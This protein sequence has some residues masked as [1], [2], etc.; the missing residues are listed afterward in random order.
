MEDRRHAAE[1]LVGLAPEAAHAVAAL[2]RALADEDESTRTF[3]VRTLVAMGDAAAQA[4][5]AAIGSPVADIRAAALSALHA[6]GPRAAPYTD[7]MIEAMASASDDATTFRVSEVLASIG[8]AA[9]QRLVAEMERR[10]PRTS[11]GAARA[12]AKMNPAPLAC[13]DVMKRWLREPDDGLRQAATTVVA[14]WT[15]NT[16]VIEWADAVVPLAEAI[17]EPV[18]REQGYVALRNLG[19]G[20]AAAVPTLIAILRERVDDPLSFNNNHEL[21]RTSPRQHRGR[22]DPG[23]RRVHS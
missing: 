15:K 11:P 19:P 23:T 6:L 7:R 20:G 9:V 21:A 12:L 17:R 8:E 1:M 13:A 10:N 18:R 2:Q 3:A 22:G 5:V 4:L 14:H 16:H